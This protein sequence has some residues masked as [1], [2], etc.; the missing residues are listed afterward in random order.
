M[1]ELTAPV[2]ELLVGDEFWDDDQFYWRLIAAPQFSTNHQ[3]F[4]HSTCVVLQVE[5]VDGGRGSRL[6][7]PD[8]KLKVRRQVTDQSTWH[9]QQTFPFADPQTASSGKSVVKHD[10][11]G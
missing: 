1:P 10:R 6:F 3:L 5:Y 2:E 9:V 7:D 4:G 8:T 11:R